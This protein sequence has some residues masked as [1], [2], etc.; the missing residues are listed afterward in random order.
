MIGVKVIPRTKSNCSY[1]N[2]LGD[3]GRSYCIK[4]KRDH[5]QILFLKK[6]H[7]ANLNLITAINF[8]ERQRNLLSVSSDDDE[9]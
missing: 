9:L 6:F 7:T 4:K 1:S 8:L 2:F 5:R 3:V